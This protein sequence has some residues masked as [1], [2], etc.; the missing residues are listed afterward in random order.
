MNINNVN[1]T[2]GSKTKDEPN[3]VWTRKL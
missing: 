1:K 3:I 2:N